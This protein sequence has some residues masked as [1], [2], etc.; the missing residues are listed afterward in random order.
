MPGRVGEPADI[1]E[2]VEFL[3]SD[4]GRW[5]TGQSIVASGGMF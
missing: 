5:I 2:V 1:A 3:A 4:R